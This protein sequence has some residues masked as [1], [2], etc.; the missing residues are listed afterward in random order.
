MTVWYWLKG[1]HI[2]LGNTT[3]NR[4]T[5]THKYAQMIFDKDAGATQWRKGSFL[6]KWCWSNWPSIEENSKVSPKIFYN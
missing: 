1:R 2:S 3:V 4:E 6:N 5:D